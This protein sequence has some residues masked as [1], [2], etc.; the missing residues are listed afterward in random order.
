MW[1]RVR[2]E[3]GCKHLLPGEADI[4]SNKPRC[5]EKGSGQFYNLAK[6]QNY[7][8]SNFES[9]GFC[10][11]SK[12]FHLHCGMSNNCVSF[13][14]ISPLNITSPLPLSTY[15]PDK[16]VVFSSLRTLGALFLV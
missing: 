3:A 5:Q 14:L 16:I 4:N 9:Y 6:I 15:L 2:L 7:E 10:I 12:R 8:R 11:K 13:N 1:L